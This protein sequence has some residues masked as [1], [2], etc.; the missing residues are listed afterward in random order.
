MPA[1]VDVHERQL[2]RRPFRLETRRS[3][4]IASEWG[5]AEQRMRMDQDL[6][7]LVQ[8]YHVARAKSLPAAAFKLGV[9]PTWL[10]RQIKQLESHLGFLLFDRSDRNAT[11]T[12]EGAEFFES[13]KEI[14]DAARRVESVARSLGAGKNELLFGLADSSFWL[15]ARKALLEAVSKCHPEIVLKTVVSDTTELMNQLRDR[16]IDMCLVGRLHDMERYDFLTIHNGSPR[17]LVPEESPLAKKPQLSMA[18]ISEL[19]VA[20]PLIDN[21]YSFETIYG[22]FLG[23]GA[24]PHWVSEGP[25]A[26]FH[27]ALANRICLV[28][29]GFEDSVNSSLL[30]KEVIDS[31]AR[32][33]VVVAMN[34]DDDREAVRKVWQDVVAIA[35]KAGQHS[36]DTHARRKRTTAPGSS[37]SG[38]N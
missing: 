14:A 24:R 5:S 37:I 6:R 20:I 17:L 27:F 34:A 28:A 13:V 31:D 10:S 35:A 21:D 9:E 7:R 8:F 4:R 19:D 2:R 29:W 33:E 32:V 36:P 12:P 11:L 18:D 23:A 26:A 30:P 1:P 16:E 3:A 15:P 38:V 22:P 25:L